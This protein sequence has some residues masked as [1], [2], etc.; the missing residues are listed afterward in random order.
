MHSQNQSLSLSSSIA[1]LPFDALC[2]FALD[3]SSFFFMSI[4]RLY[5]ELAG[6]L[7]DDDDVDGLEARGDNVDIEE[8]LDDGGD[9]EERARNSSTA[10]TSASVSPATESTSSTLQ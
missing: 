7:S 6:P 10:L 9:D 1:G 2:F 8:D 5:F 4:F 3:S